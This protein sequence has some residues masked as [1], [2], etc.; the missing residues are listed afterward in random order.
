MTEG[1]RTI[2]IKRQKRKAMCAAVQT[3]IRKSKIK[4]GFA[5]RQNP[6]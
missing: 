3:K 2:K 4:E 6:D 1:F 5:F